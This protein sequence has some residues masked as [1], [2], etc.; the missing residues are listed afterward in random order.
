MNSCDLDYISQQREGEAIHTHALSEYSYAVCDIFLTFIQ[1][2]EVLESHVV[3][4]SMENFICKD[5][6]S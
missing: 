5:F 4:C 2:H 3:D 1:F 6:R